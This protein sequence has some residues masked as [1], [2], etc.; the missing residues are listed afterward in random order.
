MLGKVIA[1]SWIA[2][3]PSLVE[4]LIKSYCIIGDS[5]VGIVTGYGVCMAGVW[6]GRGK[7][8]SLLHSVQTGS[9][10]HPASYPMCTLGS[11]PGGEMWLGHETDHSSA[12]VMNDGAIPPLS[13][14]S[15][16]CG[17]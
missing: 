5:S 2:E 15:S 7:R 6:P 11:F 14:T 17:A 13:H 1:H 16:W 8:F 9:G 10:A 12:E 3:V 4:A